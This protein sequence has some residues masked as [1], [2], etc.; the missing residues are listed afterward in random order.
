MKL[1]LAIVLIS[2]MIFLPQKAL[3]YDWEFAEKWSGRLLLAVEGAGEAWYVNP[4]NLERYY[5][6]RPADAFKMMQKLGV[7]ISETDF[8]QIIKSNPATAV[9]TKLLDNLSGQII[10]QVEKN[11]EAWYID[12]V[13]R[14]ALSLGTPLAAW[15][16][17]RAKAVGITNN[18][19]TKIKNIDTPAGRPAPVY[20]KGLYLTG[21]SAGN[22]T[23]RQQIIKYLKDNNLN[24]VVIDIKDAS[25]YVLYQS[26][27]PEVIKNVLIVDLAA[28][29]AEFQTQGIY[30]I[31]R[32]V[33]FL[34][35]KLA[36]KKPSWAV[37]S[38]S[39]GVWH[40]ASG[41]AWMDP[42]IQE[43]WDY[44]LAIA[45]EAIKAG[46]DEINFD[47]VRFPSDGA[48]GSAVYR[49]LNTTKALA[50]K[51]FFKYLD[52][53]L[54]DE[55][56]W[57][58][59]DFFGLTLDSA[60]TSYDLGIGQRLA[61]ARLNVDYIYPMAYPSHYSTGYLGYKNPAD[62]PYQVISTGLKKAHPLMS[63]GRAKLR[64]WIQAFDLGAVYDQTKIKQEIKAVEEDS[65]VQGWVMWNA[66]NVYQNIE[67]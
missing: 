10:L 44:N 7:G 4:V 23:K 49:H 38:V 9:K 65:T 24:T 19:L 11:G 48:I 6:G 55:P 26:Q 17:M 2:I 15:Q 59:V 43:V 13:S 61:D 8:A 3:A 64:V 5:L 16:L 60:N 25:G 62:Y 50:L 35:P 29:F 66:R 18:N 53:N 57:V 14:Q 36:A 22:A 56:A 34:D 28:V 67:I 46:A 51:S 30:V 58:S 52:Q 32:Q 39:G 54:A 40:D 63:K 45:K 21:Y 47:Y 41:S 31:A 20:T 1:R 12:P 27:I 37:S 33:V 42:T